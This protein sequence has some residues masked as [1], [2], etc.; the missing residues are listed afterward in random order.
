VTGAGAGE[1]IWPAALLSGIRGGDMTATE[2][3]CPGHRLS[4]ASQR[5]TGGSSARL[6]DSGIELVSS[7]SSSSASDSWL[8]Q[9]TSL[10]LLLSDFFRLE[11]LLQLF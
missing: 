4:D 9:V 7:A 3:E 2:A 5:L 11:Y 8:A 10:R 1:S 6:N